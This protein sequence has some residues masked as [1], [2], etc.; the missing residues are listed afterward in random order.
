[1]IEKKET[2]EIVLSGDDLYKINVKNVYSGLRASLDEPLKQI[3]IKVTQV[4]DLNYQMMKNLK[5]LLKIVK[6]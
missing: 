5:K 6:V 1:M 2:K 4:D 3:K